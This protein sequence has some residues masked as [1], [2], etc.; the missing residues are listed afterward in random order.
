M[1]KSKKALAGERNKYIAPCCG[2]PWMNHPDV[3]PMCRELQAA[4]RENVFLKSVLE[5]RDI[6]RGKEK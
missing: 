6:I 2:R 1:A 5:V 3:I 4:L